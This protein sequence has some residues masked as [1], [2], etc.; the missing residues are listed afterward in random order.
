MLQEWGV[1][2]CDPAED[3][4]M[5]VLWSGNYILKVMPRWDDVRAKG[6]YKAVFK[7]VPGS[8]WGIG[9]PLMMSASQDRAN[10]LMIA[11]LDNNSWGTGPIMWLDQ[12]RLVNVNDAKDMH[13][14]KVVLTHTPMGATGPPMGFAQV[15]LKLAELMAQ[16]RQCLSDSDNESAVPAYSYG[17]NPTGGA[18]STY[19]GLQTL[20]NSAAKGIKDALLSIDQAMEA[21]ISGWADWNNEYAE[22][23]SVKG[24]VK[25]LCS[26]STGMFVAEMR[27]AKY[28]EFYAQLVPLL[29]LGTARFVMDLLRTKAKEQGLDASLLPSDEEVLAKMA[30]PQAGPAPESEVQQQPPAEKPTGEQQNPETKPLTPLRPVAGAVNQ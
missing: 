6:Y 21:F 23:E 9:V 4:N 27:L 25:V 7:A 3:Y 12:T 17:Q 29:P 18:A 2:N 15:E 20:M 8:F 14:H 11:M 19:S 1:G 24:G 28:D 22:D 26:G 16:Y 13:P 10:S 5:E 30:S